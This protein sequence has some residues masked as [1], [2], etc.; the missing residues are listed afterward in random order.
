M[1]SIRFWMLADIK[2]DKKEKNF[3][4]TDRKNACRRHSN[5]LL[6]KKKIFWDYNKLIRE[7]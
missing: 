4:C 2:H 6:P 3:K 5:A 7:K 1:Q